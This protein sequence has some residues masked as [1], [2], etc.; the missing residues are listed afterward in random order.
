MT[1]LALLAL[2]VAL[3]GDPCPIDVEVAEVTPPW[4]DRS[5]DLATL[6]VTRSWLGLS[7][8]SSSRG[9]WVTAVA[10]GGPMAQGGLKQ[11][12]HILEIGGKA[13][14]DKA[15][16]N[17]A[18]DAVE[19]LDHFS[20]R[21]EREGRTLD[22][23]LGPGPADPLVLGLVAAAEAQECRTARLLGLDEEQTAAVLKGAFN[24]QKG[25]RCEDAHTAIAGLPSGSLVVVRGGKR[26]L[27]TAPGWATTCVTV[28]S[29]DGEGLAQA[30]LQ[31]LLD[32]VLGAYVQDRHDN[33]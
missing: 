28:E 32:G 31:G 2:P 15:S 20:M 9:A 12:D 30:R 16:I 10:A 4:R 13:V 1:P 27:L 23:K 22:L 3:A 19:G 25:F 18:F 17:A 7:W 11:G 8:R 26:V 33:P 24:D 14:T 5:A 29:V 21:V 6:K